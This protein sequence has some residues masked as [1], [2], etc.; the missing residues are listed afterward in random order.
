MTE[1]TRPL[2]GRIA[3]VT[4]ASRGFGAAVA[5]RLAGAGAHVV[6]AARTVGGLEETDDAIKAVGGSATLVPMDLSKFEQID[7]LGGSLAQRFGKLDILVG[8]AAMLG[9]LGPVAYSDAKVWAQVLDLNLTANY[10]LIRSADALLRAAA[11]PRAVF[12]TDRIARTGIAYWNAYAVAKAGLDT[13]AGLY[14]AETAKTEL[15]VAL[16]HPG[17][18]TSRLREQGFPGE[19]QGSQPAPDAAADRLLAHLLSG[20]GLTAGKVADWD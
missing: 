16:F 12:V 7:L 18:M 2:E 8:S 10:R 15:R 14:A 4:G 9:H 17:P 20:D 11:A 1:T 6:C 19:P 13:L 5:V 3:L